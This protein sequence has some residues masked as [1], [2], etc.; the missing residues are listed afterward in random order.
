MT[1]RN[2]RNRWTDC[3]GT[4]GRNRPES[5]DGLLRNQWTDSPGIRTMSSPELLRA[6]EHLNAGRSYADQIKPFNFLLSA[7]VAT[8]GH[9]AGA[10]PERF[11]LVAPFESDPGQWLQ[12]P[13]TDV[14]SRERVPVYTRDDAPAA[15]VDG[16]KL[17]TYA[18]V[19]ASYRTH[20][21][22]KSAGV[23][24][25]AC[26]RSTVGLLC[27]RPVEVL[28][29][30]YIGKES[31][32]LEEVDSGL[33]HHIQAVRHAYGDGRKYWPK[34]ACELKTFSASELARSLRISERYVKALRNRR[35]SPS[36][37][38]L[39]RILRAIGREA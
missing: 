27:R 5:V 18:D 14:Y 10:D 6:F 20:P 1:G 34:T 21:E 31:N 16:A 36:S 29:R 11:H 4:G 13:W 24:G 35:A 19:Y 33:V 23:D 37:E 32:R 15:R 7:H 25:R 28:W 39:R 38:L 3:F 17:R 8:F 9:P 2:P 30:T 26:G 12:L 22:P